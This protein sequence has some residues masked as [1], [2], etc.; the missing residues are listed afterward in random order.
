[1]G[2]EALAAVK[3]R[4]ATPTA[5]RNLVGV[6]G[7]RH[8]LSAAVGG[9]SDLISSS[10]L[11]VASLLRVVSSLSGAAANDRRNVRKAKSR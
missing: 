11:P 1:M 9:G 3:A 5:S 4:A 10:S 2:Q 6:M 7:D 8:F